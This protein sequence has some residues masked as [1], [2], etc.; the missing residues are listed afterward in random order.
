MNSRGFQLETKSNVWISLPWLTFMFQCLPSAR[1]VWF[2]V[3]SAKV[4]SR[5][6]KSQNCPKWSRPKELSRFLID[7]WMTLVDCSQ[8]S[9]LLKVLI[10]SDLEVLNSSFHPDHTQFLETYQIQR[11]LTGN[12]KK[13]NYSNPGVTQSNHLESPVFLV[14]SRRRKYQMTTPI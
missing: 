9:V 1:S 3:W 7:K 10:G 2:S 8:R 4:A 12:T 6:F 5:A 11:N 13:C 14:Q